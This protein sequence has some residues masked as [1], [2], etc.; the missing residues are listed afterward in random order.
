M[1]AQPQAMGDFMLIE[2]LIATLVAT[3]LL[4]GLARLYLALAVSGDLQR[5]GQQLQ[6]QLLAAVEQPGAE[7]PGSLATEERGLRLETG[8]WVEEAVTSAPLLQRVASARV[9]SRGGELALSLERWLP[10]QPPPLMLLA[11]ELADG[12]G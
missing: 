5:V 4:C 7:V 2:Q 12:G 3:V 11:A 6:W 10:Q 8:G 9:T 1:S